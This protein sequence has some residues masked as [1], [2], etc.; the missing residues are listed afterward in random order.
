MTE[1]VESSQLPSS[2]RLKIDYS[3]SVE[4]SF[5]NSNYTY[6]KYIFEIVDSFYPYN[7]L[8][9]KAKD[10]ESDLFNNIFKNGDYL[11]VGNAN[12][13]KIKGFDFFNIIE[14]DCSAQDNYV[15]LSI[16]TNKLSYN[17]GENI[18][19]DIY[20]DNVL[21]NLTYG[22]QSKLARKETTFRAV[23]LS[24]KVVANYGWESAQKIIYVKNRSRIL[25]V[26][27]I[28]LVIFILSCLYVLVKKYWRQIWQ[29][30]GS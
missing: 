29:S 18:K 14:K 1:V 24:N 30:V 8:T 11:I 17:E 26:Y 25:L 21:V 7:I 9:L 6:Y 4:V 20:P 27:Q 28:G 2:T 5:L 19:I 13:C 12:E 16:K 3:D 15:G 23:G 22:G 10:Y